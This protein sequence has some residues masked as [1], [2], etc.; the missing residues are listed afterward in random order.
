[1]SWLSNLFSGGSSS[2]VP[3]PPNPVQVAGA[4]TSQNISTAIAN[5]Y[6]HTTNQTTPLGS[7][8]Y[9]ASN[10]VPYTDPATGQVYNIPQFTAAQT[11]SPEQQAI[12]TQDQATQL[13]LSNL[14]T[15][16]SSQL[17]S[18]LGTPFA[19]TA[20]YA[21]TPA[22]GDPNM[23]SSLPGPQ[24][25]FGNAGQQQTSLGNYG[26]QQT[27][28][29]DAGNITGSY[30][31]S[32]DFSSDRARVEQSLYG[33]LNPQ[34]DRERTNVE[35]RLADQG[36]RYGTGAY[37][38]A[39]DDYNRQANDLRLGVTQTAGAEQQRMMDMAAQRAGFQNSAQMQAY[40]EAQG[41][42]TFANQ[43]QAQQ[44]QETLGA[45]QFANQAQVSQFG[46]EASRGQFANAAQAQ[47]LAQQQAVI[48]A[49]NTARQNYLTEQYALRDQPINEVTGLLSGSQ[50]HQPVFQQTPTN[51]I[52]TTD[53]AGL[54]NQN[55]Q[56][57]LDIY[58]QQSTNQ[59]ALIGGVLG[60]AGNILGARPSDRRI[61]KDIH[62]MGTVFAADNEGGEHELPIYK[63]SYKKD[64]ASVQHIGPM[65]QDMEKVDPDAVFENAE[66]VK[67]I[68]TRHMMGSIMRAA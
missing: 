64:P 21:N 22:A 6:L 49:Q 65:A 34:L 11:L 23:L 45:G 42:G 53:I 63:Y 38:A 37:N 50:V 4:Q 28:F 56:Q 46:Q 18:I 5:A 8:T 67:H 16:Q 7:L 12:Q 41:R 31:P 9:S 60:A 33:R 14:G 19:N 3:Q 57:N 25:T 27:T 36:I 30:G 59:N 62:K 17:G 13:N 51:Q 1:M 20:A 44:F 2:S 26:Q 24:S 58:K 61:K 40:N 29:G 54:L 39:M 68:K 55:F 48:N 47:A 35:Q 15:A 52:P 32:D 66:G 43:A 10:Q